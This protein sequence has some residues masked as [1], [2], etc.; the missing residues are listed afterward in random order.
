[1]NYKKKFKDYFFPI[2]VAR[3]LTN[4]FLTLHFAF[5]TNEIYFFET[6][7]EYDMYEKH[8]DKTLFIYNSFEWK[9]FL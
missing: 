3:I 6:L 5:E 8:K 7:I 4:Y 1:L 9:T 2:D